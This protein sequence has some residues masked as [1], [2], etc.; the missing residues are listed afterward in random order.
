MNKDYESMEDMTIEQL[1]AEKRKLAGQII[2]LK[3]M[4]REIASVIELKVVEGKI[5]TFTDTE[6][7]SMRQILGKK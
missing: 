6:R 7:E 2:A 3:G 1:L 4:Q 5:A